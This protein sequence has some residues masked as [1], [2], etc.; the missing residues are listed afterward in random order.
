MF[1]ST[2]F[3]RLFSSRRCTRCMASISSSELVMRARHLVFHVQCFSC[4]V[5]NSPLTK[6]DQFGLRNSAIFCH[7]HYEIGVESSNNSNGSGSGTAQTP[8]RLTC[9]YEPYGTSPNNGRT[10]PHHNDTSAI[11]LT[12]TCGYF[13]SS[14]PNSLAGLAQTP[15][16]K[17][18]PRK[19]KPK[20]IEA[21]TTNMGMWF[22]FYWFGFNSNEKSRSSLVYFIQCTVPDNYYSGT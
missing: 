12:S 5:C 15:R 16:Q 18:R 8:M 21:M 22:V 11:K 19:R 10:S 4:F 2:K 14:T 6:G 3:H 20:D 9:Q 7:M 13:V 17:G 1:S